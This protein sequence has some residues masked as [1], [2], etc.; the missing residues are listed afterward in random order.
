[1]SYHASGDLYTGF[2]G[3]RPGLP[4]RVR[5]TVTPIN[6]VRGL[7]PFYNGGIGWHEY[8]PDFPFDRVDEAVYVDVRRTGG[9]SF[10][11][12]LL[13]PQDSTRLADQDVRT[14]FQ[15]AHV[16][17]IARTQPWLVI[18]THA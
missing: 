8:L 14:A 13:N 4:P 2:V 17:I 9:V 11:L 18:W 12:G 5:T 7:L 1:M 15:D 16:H 6:E 3:T 10:S